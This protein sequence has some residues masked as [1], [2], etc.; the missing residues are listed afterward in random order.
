MPRAPPVGSQKALPAENPRASLAK[1]K[2]ATSRKPKGT[3][4]SRCKGVDTTTHQQY[5]EKLT[6][7]TVNIP[8]ELPS[9]RWR[10]RT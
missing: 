1:L 6:Q 8:C 10:L 5:S 2:G 3:T 7:D 4:I 9:L